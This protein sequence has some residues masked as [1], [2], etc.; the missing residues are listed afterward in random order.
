MSSRANDP[1]IPAAIANPTP[2]DYATLR[3][4]FMALTNQVNITGRE[5]H[6]LHSTN[7]TLLRENSL[8]KLDKRLDEKTITS[9]T[10]NNQHLHIQVEM[11]AKKL[12]MPDK[13]LAR[14]LIEAELRTIKV[15]EA[16][17]KSNASWAHVSGHMEQQ[18]R[19]WSGRVEQER[20]EKQQLIKEKEN[21]DLVVYFLNKKIKRLQGEEVEDVMLAKVQAH[22]A[23]AGAGAGRGGERVM[24]TLT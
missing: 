18:G 4:R 23:E 24:M 2:A 15:Q 8:L 22:E 12:A 14:A 16:L 21:W 1:N 9:L 6:N 10:T 7:L 20:A 11:A 17:D 13:A 5:L 19:W 3:Q